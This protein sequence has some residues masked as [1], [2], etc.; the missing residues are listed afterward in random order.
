[1]DK[2]TPQSPVVLPLYRGWKVEF[3]DGARHAPR[4][5]RRRENRPVDRDRRRARP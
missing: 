5:E 4:I 3:I 2:S 1:M